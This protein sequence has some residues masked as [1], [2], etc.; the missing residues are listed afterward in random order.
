VRTLFLGRGQAQALLFIGEQQTQEQCGNCDFCLQPEIPKTDSTD[1]A[2]TI[3]AAVQ[4]TGQRFGI[5]YIAAVLRGKL[6]DRINRAGH[7]NL[8]CFGALPDL[9]QSKLVAKIR[10]LIAHELLEQTASQYPVL[11]ITAQGRD[12]LDQSQTLLL[13]E[14]PSAPK[15]ITST[16]AKEEASDPALFEQLRQLRKTLAD[17]KRVPPYIIFGDRTLHQMA[18]YFPQTPAALLKISGVGQQKMAEFGEA[19]L[20]IIKQYAKQT[21]VQEVRRSQTET[22]PPALLGAT[23]LQTRELVLQALPLEQIA[24]QRG[25][26][27]GTIIAHLEK[28][29][30]QEPDLDIEY[31]RPD[32]TQLQ[33]IN[34]CFLDSTDLKLAPVKQRLGDRFSYDEIRLARLFV[35]KEATST[36]S[37]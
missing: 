33:T 19:F 4:Q 31:L 14:M 2:R 27:L 8:A 18:T 21:G 7:H 10:Q 30:E 5:S 15:S 17:Q 9:A 1:L 22:A 25:Y 20:K 3:L 37:L 35:I 24:K 34:D 11:L 32:A 12:F 16:G 29:A 13:P 26:A 28:I 6:S 23:Y 36:K